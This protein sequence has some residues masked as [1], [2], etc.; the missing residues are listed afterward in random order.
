[1]KADA[2]K[3]DATLEAERARIVAALRRLADRLE[4]MPVSRISEP[5]MALA[6]WVDTLE[7]AAERFFRGGGQR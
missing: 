7:R 1:M 5:I 3:L 6:G 2:K 4:A